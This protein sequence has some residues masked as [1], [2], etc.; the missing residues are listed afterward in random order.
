MRKLLVA[1]TTVAL[2][3]TGAISGQAKDAWNP[4]PVEPPSSFKDNSEAQRKGYHN[5]LIQEQT[6]GKSSFGSFR[7]GSWGTKQ[8]VSNYK[9]CFDPGPNGDCYSGK[10]GMYVGSAI[11][12]VCGTVIESC[13]EK[14]WIYSNDSTASEAS[15]VKALNG[16]TTKGYPARGI[17]T[18]ATP[19]VW[20]SATQHT[21]GTG[22]YVV[23]AN[24]FFNLQGSEMFVD[25]LQLTVV[26]FKEISSPG[27]T[28]PEYT[29]CNAGSVGGIDRGDS[30]GD[31]LGSG[32][33]F[34]FGCAYT[35]DDVCGVSQEFSDNTRV[36]VQL[37]LHNKITGW[38]HGRVKAPDLQ[39]SRVTDTYN[40]VKIDAQPVQVSRFATQS[41]PDQ[42]DKNP[43]NV[44][45]NIGFA[46]AFTD[47]GA[48]M[49]DAFRVLQNYRKSAKDT[50]AGV[51]TIWSIS[52]VSAGEASMSGS[53]CLSDTSRVLGLVTTNA[54]AYSGSAPEFRGGFLNYE[55][56]G[57][58]YL[59]N[60]IELSQG[61]YDLVM[62][63]DVARCLYGFSNAPLSAS[64]SVV[65]N[66]GQRSFATTVVNE[67]NG[68]LK[69]AAYG[70]TFSKKV[71][72]VKITKAKPKSKRR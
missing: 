47:V 29:V 37:K 38:F 67:K 20:S 61:T 26:P 53:Q 14:V 62:R 21:G 13:I 59:P 58:H 11:L 22:E 46:G 3:F 40:R 66:K 31:C 12:P 41:R 17:P 7:T 33:G 45:Q 71:I 30:V 36:G 2:I 42:G 35:Q 50:A 51:S 15:F 69:M 52:S 72:K 65:N 57:M 4:V 32:S 27:L 49:P 68:W 43:L 6:Y 60:G 10:S 34:S 39:V 23:M 9:A 1:L 55:V 64:V 54:T 56:A 63:S 28:P 70:F 24:M 5:L 48:T 19:T 8:T 25:K 44:I 18:G 16:Q